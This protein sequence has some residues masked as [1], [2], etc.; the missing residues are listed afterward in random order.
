MRKNLKAVVEK[1]RKYTGFFVF[2]FSLE[3]AFASDVFLRRIH[4]LTSRR[5][6][7]RWINQPTQEQIEKFVLLTN[8]TSGV[9]DDSG[10]FT[11]DR[12]KATPTGAA[13]KLN[14]VAPDRELRSDEN[15]R[16][17]WCG[18]FEGN[19]Q[20]PVVLPLARTSLSVLI[21]LVVIRLLRMSHSAFPLFL[22]ATILVVDW[23]C[24]HVSASH[25]FHSFF[26]SVTI[27]AVAY[28]HA[29]VHFMAVNVPPKGSQPLPDSDMYNPHLIRYYVQ[30]VW[31]LGRP[32]VIISVTG[33]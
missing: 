21:G 18:K 26:L 24:H 25:I 10:A 23:T 1:T 5:C 14:Q 19:E 8:G 29:D 11:P 3:C 9:Y 17:P 16:V 15:R 27:L 2:A 30:H 33:K 12:E 32:D 7:R 6:I 28:A 22:S 4:I 13:E 31:R 20:G